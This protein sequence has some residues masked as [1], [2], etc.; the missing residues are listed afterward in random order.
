MA[1]VLAPGGF[2]C[3]YDFTDV[4]PAMFWG[5]SAQCWGFE[6]ERD[7]SL[8]CSLPRWERL[9]ADAGFE[10]ARASR[11]AEQSCSVMGTA[12]CASSRRARPHL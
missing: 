7:Y 12:A 8:W 1:E 9:L 6:D 3:F 11:S 4:T 2:L 10:Q 5:L